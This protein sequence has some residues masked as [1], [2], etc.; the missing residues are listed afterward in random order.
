MWI[1]KF[2]LA[3]SIFKYIKLDYFRG[4]EL[5]HYFKATKMSTAASANWWSTKLRFKHIKPFIIKLWEYNS[6]VI[7]WTINYRTLLLSTKR[8]IHLNLEFLF[9]KTASFL[10]NHL[11]KLWGTRFLRMLTIIKSQIYMDAGNIYVQSYPSM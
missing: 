2:N 7:H 1:R 6:A 3:F 8:S 4:N 10:K 9:R 5:I 11:N